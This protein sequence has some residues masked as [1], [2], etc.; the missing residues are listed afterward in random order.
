MFHTKRDV[1]YAA[2]S[3]KVLDLLCG[4]QLNGCSPK[5]LVEYLGNNPFSPF[6][7]DI[8]ITETSYHTINN[9][10][11][12]PINTSLKE[13]SA[14][15]NMQFYKATACSCA[16]CIDS[17]PVPIPPIILKSCKIMS[18]DCLD[19]FCIIF[20]SVLSISFILILLLKKFLFIK[21]SKLKSNEK[22]KFLT[23]YTADSIKMIFSDYYFMF[24]LL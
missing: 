23:K 17:C 1:Q 7:F 9:I 19:V 16:D 3:Q 5:A 10:H 12:K 6:I 2:S 4:A 13:C 18:L 21:K 22:G 11:I 15:I 8:N 14:N 24:F 20:F